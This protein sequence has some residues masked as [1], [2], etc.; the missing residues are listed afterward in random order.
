MQAGCSASGQAPQLQ[1]HRRRRA[2]HS[3]SRCDCVP[4]LLCWTWVI[5]AARHGVP[6]W[7]DRLHTSRCEGLALDAAVL[8]D[9]AMQGPEQRSEVHSSRTSDAGSGVAAG[10]TDGSCPACCGGS[11]A[12]AEL[13]PFGSCCC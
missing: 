6:V 5:L 7:G 9:R 3:H 4:L 13:G 1:G 11:A 8:P 10:L 2:K 12:A